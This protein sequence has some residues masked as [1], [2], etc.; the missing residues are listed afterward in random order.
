MWQFNGQ[1][2]PAPFILG[3]E[4]NLKKWKKSPSI[5]RVPSVWSL[6]IHYHF[7][8]LL[9]FFPLTIKHSLSIFSPPGKHP[10]PS[11]VSIPLFPRWFHD[12]ANV[13]FLTSLPWKQS[14]M[15]DCSV[16][17][18]IKVTKRGYTFFQGTFM[19]QEGDGQ[20]HKSKDLFP[21]PSSLA[22]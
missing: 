16:H 10:S 8:S 1:T 5:L 3:R 13:P 19:S 15:K 22:S 20:S 4:N 11:S 7:Y 14:F 21:S 6:Y 12:A 18:C 17:E 9:L 2:D